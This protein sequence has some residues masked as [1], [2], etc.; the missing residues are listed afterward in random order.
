M[1]GLRASGLKT[2]KQGE[3]EPHW[4][5]TLADYVTA[6]AWSLDGKMAAS[7]A[8]GEVVL[9][10]AGA[11]QETSLQQGDG[12]S[13]DCLAW[14]QDGRWLAAGGQS[15]QV[16]LWRMQSERPELIAI[17]GNPSAWVDHMAWSPTQ[18]LL[19]FSLGKYVQVWDAALGDVATTLAFDT[20][21][22]LDLTWHPDGK[23]LS[24]GG[25]QGVK[26]WTADDWDDDPYLLM[27][28]S[29]SVAIAW[30]PD[31][32]YIAS[33]NLDRTITV[34]EWENP[35]PWVMRGFPGKVRQLA[36][37][38]VPTKVGASLL[39]SASA[40]GLVVWEK[41]ADEAL[42]WEGRVLAG[43]EGIVQSMHFQPDTLL[44]ASAAADGWVCL[45]HKAQRLAQVLN[46]ASNGFACLAWH[47]KGK[48][49]AAGGQNG[50]L[51]VWSKLGRGQGFGQR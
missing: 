37:S 27:I 34:L 48:Q 21:S 9:Y 18:D 16:K 4:Q 44:L 22:A 29:A 6:I 49:L 14:S 38:D 10:Q 19:A 33:G 46:G 15:G 23:R 36:W 31:G 41:Q 2:K 26:I 8:A 32:R 30:S 47:P 17:V 5:G 7:S 24:V 13:V 12:R 25:Y 20:S 1:S 39:A 45:W 40:E 51:L 42:G 43:H 11:F 28:P 50:E 35:H 3:F